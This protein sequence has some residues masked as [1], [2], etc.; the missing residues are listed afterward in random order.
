MF[1]KQVV[2]GGVLEGVLRACGTSY[3]AYV[4]GETDCAAPVQ[5]FHIVGI[6]D[7]DIDKLISE[8][9]EV[10]AVVATYTTGQ[11]PLI[12]AQ[13]KGMLDLERADPDSVH[14]PLQELRAGDDP[15]EVLSGGWHRKCL[16]S[17]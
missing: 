5:D 11:G 12:F 6:G 17:L 15:V 16:N 1:C 4:G 3:R 14:E 13:T 10:A 7:D 9:G 8:F 2:E